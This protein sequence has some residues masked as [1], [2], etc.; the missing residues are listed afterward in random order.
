[1]RLSL[2]SQARNNRIHSTWN[3]LYRGLLL[4]MFGCFGTWAQQPSSVPVPSQ[5]RLDRLRQLQQA[6]RPVLPDSLRQQRNPGSDGAATSSGRASSTTTRSSGP[7]S[8]SKPVSIRRY[9]KPRPPKSFLG[10]WYHNLTARYNAYFLAWQALYTAQEQVRKEPNL[11]ADLDSNFLFPMPEW[12]PATMEKHNTSLEKAIE[13]CNIGLNLHPFS[14]WV[15]DCYFVIGVSQFLKG[16]REAGADNLRF[17]L[18]NFPPSRAPSRYQWQKWSGWQRMRYRLRTWLEKKQLKHA[19]RYYEAAVML[20][21]LYAYEGEAAR[22]MRVWS[23]ALRYPTFPDR[24]L[25]RYWAFRAWLEL[26]RGSYITAIQ[27]IDSALAY[28]SRLSAARLTFLKAQLLERLGEP[29]QAIT[30]YQRVERFRP[31]PELTFAAE[32][33]AMQ[34]ALEAGV[35][36]RGALRARIVRTL[37]KESDPER[38]AKLYYL[39]GLIDKKEGRLTEATSHFQQA[40]RR[41]QDPILRRKIYEKRLEIAE[42]QKNWLQIAMLVDT[43]ARLDAVPRRW[44]KSVHNLRMLAYHFR[45]L[46]HID[47]LLMLSTMPTRERVRFLR[48]LERTLAQQQR[49]Q[50]NQPKGDNAPVSPGGLPGP[51]G[52]ARRPGGRSPSWYFYNPNVVAAGRREFQRTWGQRALEDYWCLKDQA[53]LESLLSDTLLSRGPGTHPYIQRLLQ[54]MPRTQTAR[55]SLKRVQTALYMRVGQLFYQMQHYDVADSFF[56]LAEQHFSLYAQDTPFLLE[57]YRWRYLC[58]RMRGYR[59]QALRYRQKYTQL[60]RLDSTPTKQSRWQAQ[61]THLYRLFQQGADSLF[62]A[63]TTDLSPTSTGA[64]HDPYALRLLF[65][66]GAVLARNGKLTEAMA[67]WTVVAQYARDPALKEHALA[68][69]KRAQVYDRVQD[70]EK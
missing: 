57:L 31:H 38:Q 62:L 29:I 3:V 12:D 43:L 23:E 14:K 11:P 32:T 67:Y 24:L 35:L 28:A 52:V 20:G 16:E 5:F 2:H 58:A 45:T 60:A 30:L 56:A 37:K 65:L 6:P 69:L 41:T 40:L 68:L 4:L 17:L 54:A 27:Y 7:S 49:Q 25:D 39:L 44:A 34:L 64:E 53:K 50:Q 8:S 1:M 33:R 22:A 63:L 61:Y 19:P 9:R 10:R 21:L 13:K 48:R 18:Q 15:D 42:Q 47:T 59:I 46:Q 70:G 66:R 36:P 51:G 26:R 55:D